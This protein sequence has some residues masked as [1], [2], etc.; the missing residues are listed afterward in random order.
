M[1]PQ[2]VG[3]NWATNTFSFSP[4]FQG[5]RSARSN[6]NSHDPI[7]LCKL[8]LGRCGITF[9]EDPLNEKIPHVTCSS[10]TTGLQNGSWNTES[11][12]CCSPHVHRWRVPWKLSWLP[13]N[14][15]ADRRIPQIAEHKSDDWIY[16]Q[17]PSGTTVSQHRVTRATWVA[18]NLPNMHHTNH[19]LTA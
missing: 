18:K 1:G 14:N 7:T 9:P 15:W 4:H 2:R 5:Q 12:A 11:S 16:Y 8:S 6:G 19:Q 13:E 3:Y 17:P 10:L